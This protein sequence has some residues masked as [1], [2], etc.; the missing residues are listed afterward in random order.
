MKYLGLH[1]DKTLIWKT[2]VWTKRQLLNLKLNQLN[3]LLGNRSKLSLESKLLIYKVVL[4]PVWTYGLQ[5]WGTCSNSNIEIIQRFQWKVLRKIAQRPW[6]V[7]N[8]SLHQ[9]LQTPY[10]KDE[11]VR[12]SSRYIKKLDSHPNHLALNLLDNNVHVH[13]I[14]RHSVLDLPSRFV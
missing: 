8:K 14:K 5:L 3:W 11:I 1:L 9:D 4:K 2:H 10:V 12:Y 6:F 7:S 13:R